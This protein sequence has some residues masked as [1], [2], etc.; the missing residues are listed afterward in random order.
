[1]GTARGEGAAIMGGQRDAAESL[2][3]TARAHAQPNTQPRGRRAP[4]S[5]QRAAD[6]CGRARPGDG[7]GE[8]LRVH[9]QGLS[10]A[11]S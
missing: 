10:K 6:P 2:I 11:I 5:R 1:M 4:G 8:K 9:R 7:V 3:R